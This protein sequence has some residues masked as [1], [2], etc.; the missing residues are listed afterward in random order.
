MMS[1]RTRPPQKIEKP[2]NPLD[3]I[4]SINGPSNIRELF[5][6]T[7]QAKGGSK[8]NRSSNLVNN[9]EKETYRKRLTPESTLGCKNRKIL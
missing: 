5:C 4:C 6:F 3:L 2:T 7:P 8:F 9:I 1:I